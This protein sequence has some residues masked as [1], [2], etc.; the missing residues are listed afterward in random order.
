MNDL[1]QLSPWLGV[2]ACP[3]SGPGLAD[4]GVIDR[5]IRRHLRCR[6]H[7]GLLSKSFAI[8]RRVV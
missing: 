7:C 6:D 3:E 8:D 4:F 1:L 2:T 5:G